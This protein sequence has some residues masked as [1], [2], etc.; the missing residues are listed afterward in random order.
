MVTASELVGTEAPPQVVVLF[1]LP[2]TVA[3]LWAAIVPTQSKHVT[4]NTLANFLEL[5]TSFFI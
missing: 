1:Q 5:G 4:K 3:V 2:E